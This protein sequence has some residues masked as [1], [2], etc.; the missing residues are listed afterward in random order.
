MGSRFP[1]LTLFIDAGGRYSHSKEVP[2]VFAGVAIETRA[3]GEI[4][5]S[6]LMAAKGPLCKWSDGE[7]TRRCASIVF[8]LLAKRQLLCIVRIVWKNTAE[9]DQYFAEGLRLYDLA[10][11][12]AQR[13]APF[14]KPM[15]TF[16]LHQF[17]ITC[18]ELI[19]FYA[20][21]NRHRVPDENH[22]IQ[23]IDVTAVFDSDIHGEANQAICKEIFDKA[24]PETKRTPKHFRISPRVKAE[25]MTEQEEPLLILPDYLAG[26]H[27]S[28]VAYQ[29]QTE[30]AWTHLLA[31]VKP[32]VD[33]IPSNRNR[34][35]EEP[36]REA[37][38]FVPPH[39]FDDM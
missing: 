30:P 22:P 1:D 3:V 34:V 29:T 35:S 14:A 19:G 5:E 20:K 13:A 39:V 10:V 31:A 17:C 27:Y 33:R 28:R 9:W 37:E 6:L 38:Y 8:R 24:L 16:K 32:M 11:K 21:R 15:A 36:F 23:P 7:N 25:I 12:A 2:I 4:R 18:G 26:Y